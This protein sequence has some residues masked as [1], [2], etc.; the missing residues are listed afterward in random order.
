MKHLLESSHLN[1]LESDSNLVKVE[2]K[3]IGTAQKRT[4]KKTTTYPSSSRSF[5]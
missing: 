3:V 1:S 4:R 5:L 2:M